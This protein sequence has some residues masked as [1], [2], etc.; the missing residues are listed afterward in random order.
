MS[1]F[2]LYLSLYRYEKGCRADD[3]SALMLKHTA[4]AIAPS[5]KTLF[6][7]SLTKGK[8][9]KNWKVARVVA[10]P[11]SGKKDNPANFLPISLLPIVSKVLERHVFKAMTIIYLAEHTPLSTHQWGFTA[12]KSTISALLSFTHHCL[13]SLDEGRNVCCLL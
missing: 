11:K 13:K 8:F 7:L 6:N 9:P 10:V 2:V 1:F 3:I 4:K 5:L 12:K